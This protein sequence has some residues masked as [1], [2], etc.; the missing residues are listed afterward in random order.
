M[1]WTTFHSECMA[2]TGM[3][4]VSRVQFA[5]KMATAYHNCILRHFET[6]TS[7][8]TV[9]NTSPKLPMLIQGFLAVCNQNMAQHNQVNWI[10]QIGQFI[11]QYWV[12]ALITGPTGFV[13]VTSTGTWTAPPVAPNY[14]FNIILYTF[15]AVARTHLVTLTGIY[16][17]TVVIIPPPMTTPWSGGLLQTTP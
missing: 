12:G 8:G 15:E 6:L 5:E 7:G 16:T 4:H 11:L 13:N 10:Q 17:S 3:T 2:L 14:D 9:V 1:S